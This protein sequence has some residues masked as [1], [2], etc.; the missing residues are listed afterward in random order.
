MYLRSI[1]LPKWKLFL[2]RPFNGPG[3]FYFLCALCGSS[4]AGGE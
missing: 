4:E 2:G 3:K 1:I